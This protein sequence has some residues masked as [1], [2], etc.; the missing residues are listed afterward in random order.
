[1]LPLNKLERLY[2]KYINKILNIAII[3]HP[4]KSIK[5]IEKLQIIKKNYKSILFDLLLGAATAL[6]FS[7]FIYFEHF[8]LT[9]K[10][11][12]SVF[13]VLA[14]AMLLYIPK[15]AVLAAGFFIGLLWFYWIGYSFKYNGVSNMESIITLLFGVIYMSFFGVLALT[16]TIAL[17]AVLLF[18][19]SFVEPFDF[20]WLQ[21]ELLFVES[22]F[23]IFK[24][25]LV[26]ILTALLLPAYTKKPYKYA[27]LLLL[28]LALNFNPQTQKDAPL[29]I[30]LVATDIKQ[31]EKWKREN[32]APTI[33]L[34][35]KEIIKAKDDG[36]DLVIF[37]ESVFPFYMNRSKIIQD[38]LKTFSNDIAIVAG[39]L[40]IEN[41]LHYNVTYMFNKGEVEVA[42]KLI[43]VPFGEY[44]PLPDFAKK[45]VNETFFAGASDFKTAKKPTDFEIEGVK[46]RNA[47][48]YEATCQEIYEGD[49]DFVI[50]ISNNA[51]FSPSIEPTLQRMLMKYYARKNAATIYH[52]ANYKGTG[53]IK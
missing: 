1:M 4:K 21:I 15:R 33:D 50:A 27:P 48:C 11:L 41:D 42:K 8:D 39:S 20:N 5:M 17:R 43:L 47:V 23:G 28:V 19:L 3:S 32:I 24:Y 36:Y 7:S 46:F 2:K 49:V 31:D 38:D 29:K 14:L 51:W 18:I 37:P 40:F 25:Q 22:Y 10:L 26:F 13:G 6:F 52:S 30:K 34:I 35:Y 16:N 44:I 9:L 53:V 12:N 45:I